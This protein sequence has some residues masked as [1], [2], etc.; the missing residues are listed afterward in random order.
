MFY[1]FCRTEG[2]MNRF[3][4]L[5]LLI[6]GIVA[7]TKAQNIVRGTVADIESQEP[8]PGATVY[9][10]D[11][12]KGAT[13]DI[14]G[15]YELSN[16][17]NGNFILEVSFVGY[18]TKVIIINLHQDTVMNFQLSPAV[19]EMTEVIITGV[20][21]STERKL[22][23]IP[24]II[25][26]KKYLFQS[27]STNIIDAIA[28]IP[29]VDQI[30]TGQSVAKPVIRGLGFNRV[31]TLYNG[32]RQEGQQWGD[33]HGIEI[34]G[35]SIDKI[36]I[37]KGPGSIAYGSD[38]MAGV[39]NFLTPHA[40]E[41]GKI[42]GSVETDY[43]TNNNLYGVSMEN[44]GNINGFNWLGRFS[45]KQAGNYRNT[46]DGKVYNSAFKELNLNGEIGIN[47]S[48][49]F[50]HLYFSNFNQELGL[51]EGERDTDGTFLKLIDNNGQAEEVPVTDA[52]LSGY[53]I[54]FPKQRI[55]HSRIG[56][57]N[58]FYF[59]KSSLHVG[60][61]YQKNVRQEFADPVNPGQRELHF[62][63]HTVNYDIKYFLPDMDQWE[64]TIGIN[65]MVQNNTNLGEE[66]LIPAY[67]MV[68]GGLFALTQQQF[69]RVLLI[70]GLRV[71]FRTID[72]EELIIDKGN[73]PE[74][75]F[76]A[77]STDF[78]NISGS[79]GVSFY[80]NDTWTFKLNMARGFRSP[81]IAEL[82]SN[83]VHEGTFRYE[84]GN[85]DLR[86]ETSLQLDLG[87]LNDSDHV[88]FE[89]GLFYN[90][91]DNYIFLQKLTSSAGGDSIPDPADP[92]PGFKY[93][94]GNAHLY[95]GE[96]VLDV[97]PHPIHWLH[98]ENS[99]ALVFARQQD[100]PEEQTN[101]PF[102][103]APKFRSELR[104][105]LEQSGKILKSGYLKLELEHYFAQN[106]IFS[107]FATETA[108][109]AYS[110]LNFGAGAGIINKQGGEL[111]SIYINA[112]NLLDTGY[113]SHLSR[114]KYAPDNPATGRS[115]VF[116]MGRNISFKLVVPLSFM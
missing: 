113:Q 70:G 43:Q 93:V 65:G 62:V 80:P 46:Y 51:V 87:M 13:A 2:S 45:K 69:T 32:L 36:E 19:K 16:L 58:Q 53:N 8:L 48:W 1:Y 4:F 50:S 76:A 92:V 56:T 104:A 90:K 29:G 27:P 57:T 54:G 47:R 59:S 78:A 108:T 30:T 14:S 89:T 82:S 111:F 9:I 35:Y 95:G 18:K 55:T 101:L 15:H 38:A 84:Y 115:G 98:F 109:P 40:V 106:R 103:P 64:T 10:P 94:Q 12:R 102:I 75:K 28:K 73:G 52:D 97:H 61:A 81:T 39:I 37:I 41:E 44:T 34:D 6:T 33:E 88:S 85:P 5:F 105:D 77:L 110:L 72:S 114:L 74:E 23:P 71:D 83:G 96:V 91:I 21:K 22:S 24:A 7:G 42:S 63:L 99:Y 31:L 60:L 107:A 68:D 26:S 49:G 20:S 17:P 25:A 86:A 3:I 112:N 79:A 67:N 116:N 11:L 100:Q 66:F